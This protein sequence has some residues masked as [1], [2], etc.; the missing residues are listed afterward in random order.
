MEIERY[1]VIPRVEDIDT[2]NK[3]ELRQ[4]MP[5]YE[6]S[7]PR[8]EVEDK[9]RHV[10]LWAVLHQF[11]DVHIVGKKDRQMPEVTITVRTNNG[12]LS[13]V[14]TG[15]H[16]KE[17]ENKLFKLAGVPQGA[18]T[19][20]IVSC[21]F[22][23]ILPAHYA[24]KHNLPLPPDASRYDIS[25]RMEYA[26]TY[27][28]F[29]ITCRLLDQQK[30][31]ELDSL[32]F[33]WALMRALKRALHEPSGLVL[34]S[35][36]TGS[37]KTTLLHAALSYL[38]DG[39]RAISTIE[40]PVELSMKKGPVKQMQVGGDITFQRALRSMMRQDPDVILVGEIRDWETMKIAIE[41]GQTGHLVFS[42]IHANCSHETV[43][44]A[45]GFCPDKEQDAIRLAETL[46][47]VLAQRLVT[48]YDGEMREREL[49]RNELDWMDINGI[50]HP[51][52][53]KEVVPTRKIG[54]MAV[55]EAIM[56]TDEIKMAMRTGRPKD[57]DIYRLARNQVQY[58]SLASA[59]MRGVESSGC[60]LREC[61][62]VL[63]SNT[64]ARENPG[65]RLVVARDQGLSLTEVSNLLDL[66]IKERDAQSVA[67]ESGLT[68][69][70]IFNNLD[71]RKR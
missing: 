54:K 2:L 38:N 47:A 58:E 28:G 34:V 9:I 26:K 51:K 50:P 48:R 17:F 21:R 43:G 19:P 15:E 57:I 53:F 14:Y 64:D 37:G 45:L 68:D 24:K 62:T 42:T 70:E 55:V 4:I 66:R 22:E 8:A 3:D 7:E 20:P 33:S 39:S 6:G 61:M 27:D 59:G 52:V 41:A 13:E 32:G 67:G 65:A 46:T 35:G 40:D 5:V 71:R 16:G 49:T 36:P 56:I 18:T 1:G 29:S 60:L 31:P 11:S 10:F 30:T 44:R 63:E 23:M 25:L 69:S 12:L